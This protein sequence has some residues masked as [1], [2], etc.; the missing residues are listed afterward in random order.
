MIELFYENERL[1][2][3]NVWGWIGREKVKL[4]I[5]LVESKQKNK[6]S[7]EDTDIKMK[8]TGQNNLKYLPLGKEKWV[9]G[10]QRPFFFYPNKDQFLKLNL[11]KSSF[12]IFIK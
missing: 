9:Q 8:G 6:T 11:F 5:S 10:E 2:R 3:I 1:R 4:L 7:I 12:K